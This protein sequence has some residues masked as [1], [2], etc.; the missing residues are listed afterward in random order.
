M[1]RRRV[2]ADIIAILKALIWTGR[3]ALNGRKETAGYLIQG[4]G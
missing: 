4:Q 2:V 3:R 1:A